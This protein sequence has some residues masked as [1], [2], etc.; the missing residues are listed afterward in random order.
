MTCYDCGANVGYF[1]LL[2]SRLVGSTGRV[3]SFEPLPE[4]LKHLRRHVDMNKRANVTIIESAL[5]D[6]IGK[7]NFFSDGSASRISAEGNIEIGCSNIDSLDL[8]PPDLIKI[9]VEGAEVLVISGAEETLREHQPMI[10][11]SLHI[12]IP[13]AEAL[14]ERIRALGYSVTF[15]K[16]SYDLTAISLSS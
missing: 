2:L 10:F 1:T 3:F 4:N 13:T 15:S 9:D 5:S 12:P 16:S 6:H 14:A 7:V 11:L 8:P